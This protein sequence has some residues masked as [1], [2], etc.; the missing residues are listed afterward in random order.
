[1]IKWIKNNILIII[2]LGLNIYQLSI[3]N[4]SK[5]QLTKIEAELVEIRN[6]ELKI[7]ISNVKLKKGS[8]FTV[9][10]KPFEN[11]KD[12]LKYEIYNDTTFI[13]Q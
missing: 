5:K 9:T 11:L 12:I 6:K 10:A 3:P 8:T 7:D 13:V 1:M 4:E 2:L